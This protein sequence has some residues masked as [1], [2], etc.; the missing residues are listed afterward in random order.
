MPLVLYDTLS[1]RK[2]AFDP[3]VPGR[4]GIYFCGPTV[5]SEPHLGHARG[6]GRLRRAAALARARGLACAWS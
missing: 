2:V 6:P 5:Y 4:A 3:V 1:R